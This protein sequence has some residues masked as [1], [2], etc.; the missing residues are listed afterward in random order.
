MSKYQ[1]S[2]FK[3]L[4]QS[5]VFAFS[6]MIDPS[7]R[8]M[9]LYLFLQDSLGGNAKTL[10]ITCIS[11]AASSFDESLSALKYANRVSVIDIAVNVLTLVC[12]EWILLSDKLIFKSL[13]GMDKLK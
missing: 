10:M 12:D 7:F 1:Q 11:P 13:A 8:N 3:P 6:V 2:K 5:Q 9:L 4:H